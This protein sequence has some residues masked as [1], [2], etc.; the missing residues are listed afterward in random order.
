MNM[1]TSENNLNKEQK[2]ISNICKSLITI[3]ND[4]AENFNNVKVDFEENFGE[5]S[6]VF[7]ICHNDL[8]LLHTVSLTEISAIIDPKWISGFIIK[9]FYRSQENL[10]GETNG[11]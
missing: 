7:K 9:K 11:Q 1:N 2:R 4:L 6:V 3:Y 5:D 8:I 10:K